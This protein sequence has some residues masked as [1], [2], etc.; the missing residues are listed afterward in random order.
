MAAASSAACLNK[1]SPAAGFEAR[2]FIF[3]APLALALHVGFVPLRKPGKL[4]G[5]TLV[6]TAETNNPRMVKAFLS[7]QS[8]QSTICHALLL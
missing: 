1:E 4:P 7:S 8:W 6:Y 3:G 2:G 5:D